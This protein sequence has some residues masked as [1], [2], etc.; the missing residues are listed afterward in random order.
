MLHSGL[1]RL[2]SASN[3]RSAHPPAPLAYGG[4]FACPA[5]ARIRPAHNRPM[6]LRPRPAVLVTLL[7]LAAC[8]P[9]YNWREVRPGGPMVALLPCKPELRSRPVPLGRPAALTVTL[10]V[11]ACEAGGLHWGLSVA[12][13]RQPQQVG[14]AL[15]AL[16]SAL[17]SNLGAAIV[18]PVGPV[19]VAG[20]TPHGES[21]Q[22]LME[23]RDPSGAPLVA[24]SWVW[25]RGSWVAQASVLSRGQPTSAQ[26]EAIAAFAAGLRTAP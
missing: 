6:R 25:A 4:A 13:V 9:T 21:R 20:Q 10:T 8:T 12:E 19:P 11:A 16:E 15:A 1:P 2:V 5:G 14:P 26:Q 3:A 22:A 18:R 17:A 7:A 24:R 23:G